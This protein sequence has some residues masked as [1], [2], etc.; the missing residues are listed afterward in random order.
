MSQKILVCTYTDISIWLCISCETDR[1]KQLNGLFPYTDKTLWSTKNFLHMFVRTHWSLIWFIKQHSEL[2]GGMLITSHLNLVHTYTFTLE[3]KKAVT[4][5]RN[6]GATAEPVFNLARVK[7][8]F[9]GQTALFSWLASM[10]TTVT[11]FLRPKM[12]LLI[13]EEKKMTKWRY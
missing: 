7:C 3:R 8:I 6:R 4:V 9:K 12:F 1:I 11:L 5:L 13:S 10:K 2:T